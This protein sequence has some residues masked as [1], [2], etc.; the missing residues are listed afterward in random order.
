MSEITNT[1]PSYLK[2]YQE[3]S[4]SAP[5]LWLYVIVISLGAFQ[6]GKVAIPLSSYPPLGYALGNYSPISEVLMVLYHE[7]GYEWSISHK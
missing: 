5:K 3:L 2:P 1:T 7:A 4:Y 6:L